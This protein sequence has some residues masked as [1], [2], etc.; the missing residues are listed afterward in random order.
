MLGTTIHAHYKIIKFL[1]M[2]RSGSAY[3][4]EN[5]DLP[6]RPPCLVKKFQYSDDPTIAEPLIDKLFEAQ[7]SI[8]QQVG[9]HSLVPTLLA[10]FAEDGSRYFVSEYIDGDL[11]SDELA[12]T[13][14]RLAN[15]SIWSQ[16]QVFDFLVDL[17]DTLEFI[18]AF[19]YIHQ[20]INPKNIIR[21]KKDGRLSLIGFSAVKDLG[22]V[23]HH[24]SKQDPRYI[25]ISIGTPGYIPYEQE[26]NKPQFNSDLYAVGAI[27]IQALTGQFP[28]LKDP[29][30][31]ELKWRDGVKINFKLM[32]IIDKMV[33][34]DY[35]NRYQSASE[36]SRDLQAF[37]LTQ[38]PPTKF[39]KLKPHLIFGAT[40]CTLSLGVGAVKLLS[41]QTN[42][43][44]VS[45]PVKIVRV[46]GNSQKKSIDKNDRVNLKTYSDKSQKFRIKYPPSWR[47]ENINDSSM[48][49]IVTFTS[50]K[51]GA[52]DKYQE[53]VS[54]RVETLPNPQ[55]TLA[56]YTKSAI[57]KIKTTYRD[58]KVIESSSI[59]MSKKPANLIVYTGRDEN[60]LPIENLEVWT[61]DRGQVYMITY[62]ADRQ[63]YYGFLQSVMTMINSFELGNS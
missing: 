4:A 62:K 5:L 24:I 27:A 23:W 18:H 48:E 6:D 28:I 3:L 59:L 8:L 57:A 33:R 43:P 44:I 45:P 25:N 55:T 29:R 58:T 61:I 47:V 37:A 2:G 56:D 1:G 10:K 52:I 49:D 14:G 9:Q 46:P 15:G 51:Q 11:L 63:Y 7:A 12:I 50:P 31:Y 34:P 42:K 38:I 26:Q 19:K 22:S 40:V 16:I 54:I 41:A 20:D 60:A 39:D 13:S 17:V 53:N 30:T 21:R 32:D 35:R 36:V